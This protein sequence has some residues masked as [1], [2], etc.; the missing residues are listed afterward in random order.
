M[1]L[2][3]LEGTSILA[4]QAV[5]K[6]FWDFIPQRYKLSE[7]DDT[8][9]NL[10]PFYDPKLT[11]ENRLQYKLVK[12]SLPNRETPW[13]V[14]TWNSDKGLLKSQLSSRRFKTAPIELP[15][16]RRTSLKFIDADMELTL[17]IASN[18]MQALFALQENILLKMRE[19]MYVISEPHSVV[20]PIT[21]AL[22][23]IDSDQTK[24]D[25]DKG[26]LCYLFVKVRIDFP[27]FGYKKDISGGIIEEIN[28]LIKNYQDIKYSLDKI[29]EEDL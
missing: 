22:N 26:T 20:G 21:V 18:S 9:L 23:M 24:L 15:S 14:I 2:E 25:R 17:G 6:L 7:N 8:V 1:D 29:T 28:L 3:T 16:G 12:N 27:V 19:K 5:Y 11:F 13:F 10:E 4:I